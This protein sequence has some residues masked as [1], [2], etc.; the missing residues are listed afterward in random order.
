MSE[1]VYTSQSEL[2]HPL[3]FLSE[4]AR[5]LRRAP[6]VAWG[7]FRSNMQA[8][9]RRAWLGYLWLLLP[10]IG[11][12]AVWVYVQSRRIVEIAPTAVPYPVYVLAGTILWQVFADALNA[13]LQ[14]LAAGR[15]MIT[16]SRVPHEA[17]ILA[18]LYEV[19]LNCAVRLVVLAAVLVVFRIPLGASVLLVPFGIAALALLGLTLGLFAAPIG[20]LYD[21]V[22]RAIALITGFWF[23]L[24]PV[25]YRVPPSGIL[26][27][28]PVTPLL[29]TTRAWMTASGSAT[30]SLVTLTSVTIIAL[31]L[32]WLFQRLARPHVVA[33]LG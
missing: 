2:R 27:F 5:D 8:R 31:V 25:L 22:G 19:L 16:R 33:R 1:T 6:G 10:T 12:T 23:F 14:Q 32:A 7:L 30:E 29:D 21:D 9:Y 3:R 11:T 4:A 15:Q 26:R 17:L 20:M 13:P 18:G 28:N 24:T